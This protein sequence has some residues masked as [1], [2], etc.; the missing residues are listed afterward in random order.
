MTENEKRL[1]IRYPGLGKPAYFED[2]SNVEC[3]PMH[4]NSASEMF[5][6]HIN[7]LHEKVERLESRIHAAEKEKT[8]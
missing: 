6:Q 7:E 2:T 3:W 4:P 8:Q 5:L 1:V